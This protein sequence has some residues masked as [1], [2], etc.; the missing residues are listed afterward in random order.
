ML[1]LLLDTWKNESIGPQRCFHYIQTYSPQFLP[2]EEKLSWHLRARKTLQGKFSCWLNFFAFASYIFNNK[3]V[4][5]IDR[6]SKIFKLDQ[7][8]L[9][10]LALKLISNQMKS[11]PWISL[12]LSFSNFKIPIST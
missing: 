4:A 2:E 1:H 6:Y 3:K 12:L 5:S 9:T 7:T 10:V 11:K 8:L